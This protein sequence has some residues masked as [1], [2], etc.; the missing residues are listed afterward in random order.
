[1]YAE[2]AW[3]SKPMCFG[4]FWINGEICGI[5]IFKFKSKWYILVFRILGVIS[6]LAK[7]MFNYDC[8]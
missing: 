6:I 4:I 1:M 5:F 7:K 3:V 2:F 8:V